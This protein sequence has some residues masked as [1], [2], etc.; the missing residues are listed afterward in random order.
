MHAK[1]NPQTLEVLE[2]PIYELR[3]YLREMSLPEDLTNNNTLPA[4][5]VHVNE[6]T[7]F[8]IY[9][10]IT[11]KL[12]DGTPTCVDGVWTMVFKP[13]EMTQEEQ[14][15][16]ALMMQQMVINGA[17]QYLDN[18]AQ[19]KT[20][21]NIL[22]ACTYATSSVPKFR[23]EGQYCVDARDQVWSA[24]NTL[25]EEVM[26]GTK[27]IPKSFDEVVSLLPVLSWPE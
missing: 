15:G 14:N 18:F 17:Q 25:L 6:A 19:T 3:A 20:Y 22:S 10:P 16:A 12:D 23:T 8:P 9:N 4:G 2:F 27:P 1:I 24:L 13:V 11:Y 5:F 26:A 7:T 21:D